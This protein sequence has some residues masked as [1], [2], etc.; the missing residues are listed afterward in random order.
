MTEPRIITLT[1]NPTVDIASDTDAVRPIHKVRTYAE[2]QD[3][4]GGGVNVAR[5]IHELGGDVLSIILSGGFPGR[6]LEELLAE[7]QVPCQALRIAGRTRVSYTVHDRGSGQEY[8]FVPEGPHVTEA[9]WRSALEALEAAEGEGAWIVASGSLPPGMPEDFYARAAEIAARQRRPLVLDTSGPPLRAALGKGVALVKPSLGEFERLIGKHLRWRE[10]LEQAALKMVRSGAA[11]RIAVTMGRDGAMLA[12]AAG[13]L[14]M[15]PVEV[16]A[17]SAVG[18]G[19]SFMGA[20][21]MAL[22]RGAT[23][24]DA[25][26]WGMAG[27]AAA[28]M[29]TGTAHP[30]RADVEALHARLREGALAI[31]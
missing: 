24:E 12:T 6:F 3:P 8:R 31:G 18:A 15:P 4:G 9:E 1:V 29:H 14:H 28:V 11:E 10:D 17:H 21:V 25:F 7:E 5:V 13:V 30:A 26:A 22:A 19:D 16:E 27:G 2:M 20:M 23:D